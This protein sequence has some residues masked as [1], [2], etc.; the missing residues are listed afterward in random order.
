MIFFPKRARS[1]VLM[2]MAVVWISGLFASPTTYADDDSG[3][4]L[5]QEALKDCRCHVVGIYTPNGG[6]E[7]DRVPV[8]VTATGHPMI[9]V[10]CSYFGTQWNLAIDDKADVRQIIVSGWFPSSLVTQPGSNESYPTKFIFG[11]GG[12]QKSDPNYFWA[13]G[14]HSA[15]GRK[16]RAQVKSLTGRDI[17]TFQCS[18]EGKSFVI[19]GK[20]GMLD[21]DEFVVQ[22]NAQDPESVASSS[23]L[24]QLSDTERSD[25]SLVEK[26]VRQL[27]ALETQEKRSRIEK[28][29]ADLKRIKEK[30]AKR[31]E[32]SDQVIEQRIAALMKADSPAIDETVPENAGEVNLIVQGWQLL[33]QQKLQ[34]ALLRF[35][36]SVKLEPSN[37]EA[38]NG[39]GWSQ[40]H[41]GRF[42]SAIHSFDETLQL[43]P[44][45]VGAMNGRGRALM[46][47]GKWDEA[48]KELLRGTLEVISEYG[49]A[50]AIES[51]VTAAWFGLVEVNILQK[52]YATAR[53][54]ASRYLKV[55]P[56]DPAMIAL[57]AQI[58]NDPVIDQSM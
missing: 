50:K 31:L 21:N 34:E 54:W 46:A 47:Q 13:Y 9:I 51:Q 3:V 44:K 30:F 4:V 52:D 42:E 49:E 10:L 35:E 6:S 23:F 26:H 53:E 7:D 37:G 39:L 1:F 33:Q 56:K 25:R 48:E 45:H 40:I 14:W 24:E 18:Y 58:Q 28:A 19:D 12:P 22:E 38:W 8:R 29:E 41:L 20:L 5:A 57:S 55:L 17:D 27:F 2:M 15:D 11:S 43:A 16:V 36:Q 32:T